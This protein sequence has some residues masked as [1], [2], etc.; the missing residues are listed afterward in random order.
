MV[1]I[2]LPPPFYA[3]LAQ[4]VEHIHGKDGVSGSSPEVGSSSTYRLLPHV[5]WRGEGV[6]VFPE[7]IKDAKDVTKEQMVL[8]SY[9]DMYVSGNIMGFLGDGDERLVI[10]SRFSLGDND[11]FFQSC[12]FIRFCF[13]GDIF[14]HVF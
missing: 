13:V 5:V 12:L 8:Q 9:N 11:F 6:F 1:Q 4:Q 10:E 7:L 2:H 14:N 3:D